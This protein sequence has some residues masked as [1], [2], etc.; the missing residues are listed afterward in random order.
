ME[1]RRWARKKTDVKFKQ[2]R[3]YLSYSSAEE[4]NPLTTPSLLPCVDSWVI[5]ESIAGNLRCVCQALTASL[6]RGRLCV[7]PPGSCPHRYQTSATHH[8]RCSQ[9]RAQGHITKSHLTQDLSD[10]TP[11]GRHSHSPC[12]RSLPPGQLHN[13]SSRAQCP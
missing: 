1:M 10:L 3:L 2:R 11:G 9:A 7:S 6:S 8:S 4:P 5:V 12:I 13:S